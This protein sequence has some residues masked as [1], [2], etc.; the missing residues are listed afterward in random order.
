MDPSFGARLRARR[1]EQQVTLADIA[2]QTKIKLS[3]LAALER[4]D[5]SHWPS[6]LFR[7]SYIRA[8]A[9]AIGLEPDAVVREFLER[10]PDSAEE[11]VAGLA[12]ALDGAAARRGPPTRLRFLIA[13]AIDA[14]PVRR[15]ASPR[16]RAA[17]NPAGAA[18]ARGADDAGPF[19]AVQP[20]PSMAAADEWTV[21]DA[22]AAPSRAADEQLPLPG[23]PVPPT[24][25]EAAM[26]VV[27]RDELAELAALCARMART[28]D[29]A[30]L[31]SVFQSA[32]SL[33]DALGVILWTWDPQGSALRAM[34]GHGYPDDMLARLGGV[35]RDADNAIAAAFRAE[36]TRVVNGSAGAT[37]AI[38]VPLVTPA[39]CVGVLA[40]ELRHDREQ[41]ESVRAFAAIIAAQLATLIG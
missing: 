9:R 16:N 1:E 19:L 29:M 27:T 15:A 25:S 7:R 32:A 17:P 30:E 18:V 36:E 38:V 10:Y 40:F 39:G 33:L 22:A 6:G 24:A 5:V 13:S 26:T 35:P 4:D 8:Y 28:A 3:L 41:R 2:E 23:V 20:E 31:E 11:S 12:T 14:L 37:G 34:F 21:S